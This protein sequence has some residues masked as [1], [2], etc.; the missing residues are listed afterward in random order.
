MMTSGE[1]LPPNVVLILADCGYTSPREI[2]CKVMRDLHLPAKIFYP[3]VRLGARLFGGFDPDETSAMDAMARCR[4]PLI[5]IHGDT[6]DFV[7]FE[8]SEAIYKACSAPKRLV[9]IKGAG[10]GLA[11]PVDRVGY[12][13]ALEEFKKEC[14][15]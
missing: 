7:P 9:A 1:P 2:I 4:V 11:F 6:D 13:R 12:V 8:M 14:G 5:L 3:L 15:I 10:H